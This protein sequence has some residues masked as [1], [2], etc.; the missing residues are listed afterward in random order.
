M[1]S[2][3]G[4]MSICEKIGVPKTHTHVIRDVRNILESLEPILGLNITGSYEE[5]KQTLLSY[6]QR[7][8]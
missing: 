8:P 3:K 6:Y 2:T 4:I 5:E 7:H 1:M